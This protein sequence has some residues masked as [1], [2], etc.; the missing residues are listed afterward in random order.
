MALVRRLAPAAVQQRPGQAQARCAGWR[1]SQQAPDRKSARPLESRG[2]LAGHP[3]PKTP[4]SPDT[5]WPCGKAQQAIQERRQGKRSRRCCRAGLAL[6]SPRFGRTALNRG[7]PSI[8]GRSGIELFGELKTSLWAGCSSVVAQGFPRS[9]P[10]GFPTAAAAEFDLLCRWVLR[11]RPK[12]IDARRLPPP[13]TQGR[14]STWEGLPAGCRPNRRSAAK[15]A[16]AAGLCRRLPI[17]P[18]KAEVEVVGQ[19]A[20]QAAGLSRTPAKG[21]PSLAS[22]RFAQAAEPHAGGSRGRP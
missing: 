5:T 8:P 7:W 16:A 3:P 21:Q 12:R 10:P 14:A 20:L 22:S 11:P 17:H 15:R 6:A 18:V 13:A 2:G 9:L 1:R 4:A 19:R